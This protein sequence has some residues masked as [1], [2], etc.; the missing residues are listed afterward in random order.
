L[1]GPNDEGCAHNEEGEGCRPFRGENGKGQLN[2]LLAFY[3]L[4][5]QGYYT[6]A[7]EKVD[8]LKIH[9]GIHF[10]GLTD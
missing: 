2:D 6:E 1:D 3:G 5:P 10:Y 9:L 4:D 8:R 7:D